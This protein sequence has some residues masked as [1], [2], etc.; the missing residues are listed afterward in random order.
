M[1]EA[2]YAPEHVAHGASL[3]PG[4]RA[5]GCAVRP[6]PGSGHS[7]R[8]PPCS[9]ARTPRPR[10]AGSLRAAT[11]RSICGCVVIKR[12]VVDRHHSG[13]EEKAG[14]LRR[15]DLQ[16]VAPAHPAR[17][18]HLVDAAV[19]EVDQV[20]FFC[21]ASRSPWAR[22]VVYQFGKHA[23]HRDILVSGSGGC[24][25]G[26]RRRRGHWCGCHRRHCRT[27]SQA[28]PPTLGWL[29]R[30]RPITL[31]VLGDE[32]REMGIKF[33]AHVV[34]DAPA[35]LAIER[36]EPRVPGVCLCAPAKPRQTDRH[37]HPGQRRAAKRLDLLPPV[38]DS[39]KAHHRVQ[40][41][42][43]LGSAGRRR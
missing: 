20:A 6:A 19:V 17:T 9:S 2:D 18:R 21:P 34:V 43:V 36:I 8:R 15:A 40:P 33:A 14:R 31:F 26:S 29:C 11:S 7:A 37:Q 3:V 25:A 28:N 10:G 13:I 27:R 42:P 5:A 30:V 24:A 22:R 32:P 35:V 4:R 41:P 23:A 12:R 16:Q 39:V 38:G 1:V